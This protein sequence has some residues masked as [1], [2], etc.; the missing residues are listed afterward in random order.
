MPYATLLP[1]NVKF[2]KRMV[3]ETWV[4]INTS[5]SMLTELFESLNLKNKKNSQ[6]ETAARIIF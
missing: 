6:L 2:T 5:P 3:I 4:F 1:S